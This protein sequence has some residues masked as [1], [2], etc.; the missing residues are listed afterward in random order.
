MGG[1]SGELRWRC[2][3]GMKELDLLLTRFLDEHYGAAPPAEQLAFRRLLDLQ[4][5]LIHDYLVGR[6]SPADAELCALIGRM[7]GLPPMDR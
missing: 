1:Q 7:T 5:P 3:R 6:Q 2:R 4:D